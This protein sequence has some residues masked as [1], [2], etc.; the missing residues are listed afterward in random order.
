MLQVIKKKNE[1]KQQF[2]M[3]FKFYQKGHNALF[4]SWMIFSGVEGMVYF[5]SQP[6]KNIGKL[7]L[8]YQPTGS[9][10]LSWSMPST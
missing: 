5:I 10:S 3:E 7:A 4:I 1:N 9:W 6:W 2:V 8:S